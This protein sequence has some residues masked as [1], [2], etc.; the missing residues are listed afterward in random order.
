MNPERETKVKSILITQPEPE[1]GR[2]VYED[3]VNRYKLTMDF[4]AFIHIEPLTAREIR[5]QK[6]NFLDYTAVIFNSRNAVDYF[7]QM[8]QEM[9][10]EMPPETKYFSINESVSNYVQKYIVP[11]KRKMF[12]AKGTEKDFFTL[13]KNHKKEKFLFP[14]SDIRKPSLPDFFTGNGYDFT[15]CIIYRTVSSDLSDLEEVF[16]D[17]I[18]FFSPADIK[19]LYDN[20]HGFK[21]NNTRIAGFGNSTQAAITEHNLILDITA[22]APGIPSMVAALEDY[23]SRSNKGSN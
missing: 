3:F 6:I 7:F 22:P 17:I 4:R 1:P 2:N 21:Q 8:A 10:V 13:F 16:Y 5:K 9:K 18:V 12:T 15:E 23:V 14:C 11:R 20:F 19:S